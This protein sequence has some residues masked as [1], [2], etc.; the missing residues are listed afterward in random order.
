MALGHSQ[1]A[2]PAG[3][4]VGPDAVQPGRDVVR[5]SAGGDLARQPQERLLGQVLGRGGIPADRRQA[6][7]QQR[8]VRQ[9]LLLDP[10]RFE[11]D[12]RGCLHVPGDMPG[13]K[14]TLD[15]SHLQ[16]HWAEAQNRGR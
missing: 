16:A 11:L 14:A 5:T 3:G 13:S 7:H 1:P 2:T 15:L 12:H 4:E 6:S 9:V 8:M 10:A